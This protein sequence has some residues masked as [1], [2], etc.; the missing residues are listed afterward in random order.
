M[1]VTIDDIHAARSQAGRVAL[2]TPVVPSASF[3]RLLG[4]DI[5]LKAENLQRTGSFKIR[6]ALNAVSRL[7]DPGR[8]V[9][10]ASAGNHAQGVALAAQVSGI[11]AI[12]FMPESAALPKIAATEAYGAEVRLG[13]ANLAEAVD[14]AEAYV[15][16]SGAHLLHPFDD[17]AIIAGQGT[18]GLELAEQLPG[19]RT[20]LVPVGGGGLISGIAV[21]LKAHDPSIRIIGVQSAA[22]P[23]YVRARDTGVLAEVEPRATVAD[24]I[25]V[26]RPSRLCHEVIERH[27]DELVAVDDDRTTEAVA[28]LLERGKFL[29]E[30]A[31]AVGAAALLAGAVAPAGRTVVVLSGG[32]IDLLLL[33]DVVRHGLATRGRFASLRVL[34]PDQPGYLASVVTTIGNAGGNILSVEHHREEVGIPF[35]KVEIHLTMETRSAAHFAT[36]AAALGDQDVSIHAGGESSSPE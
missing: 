15:A 10:A 24:G 28:L 23:T 31:G 21:A 5:W 36:I 22:V 32:N 4:G 11:P 33:D 13:G 14:R 34:V 9:V 7:T 1:T 35:G 20:V 2:E 25:A 16:E 30:P 12:V 6:G 8:G 3:S 18:L 26:S 29:V 27:V 17:P 19:L